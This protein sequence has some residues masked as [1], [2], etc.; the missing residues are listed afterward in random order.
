MDE[1]VLIKSKRSNFWVGS[2]ILI[3]VCIIVGFLLFSVFSEDWREFRF[4]E[5][6]YY[7]NRPEYDTVRNMSTLE[8]AF[9]EYNNN[10]NFMYLY[11][12]TGVSFIIGLMIIF[13]FAGTELVVTDKKVYGKTKFNKR[14][15]LP[16]D[17]ITS[18]GT[19]GNHKITVATASGLIKFSYI[20]NRDEIHKVLSDLI[21]ARQTKSYAKE[22]KPTNNS[23]YT[24]ELK[25]IKELLDAGVIT[26]EEFD[27]KKKQILG[28]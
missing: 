12:P 26:Q 6:G 5:Y 10:A 7:G 8:F 18:V 14:V 23:D 20:E 11:I 9:S 24:E 22:E 25:K 15:D 4:G 17:S 16:L 2:V 21:I 28:L 3:I 13:A 27:A 1:K 19:S